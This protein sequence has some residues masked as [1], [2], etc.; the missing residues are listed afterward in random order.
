[1]AFASLRTPQSARHLTMGPRLPLMAWPRAARGQPARRSGGC[2][3]GQPR[4]LAHILGSA[5]AAS[6]FSTP[7]LSGMPTAIRTYASPFS[8][9][10]E[11][12]PS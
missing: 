10:M 5:S 8:T 2:D 11:A 3:R 7:R 6:V 9:L 1:M 12:Y 4:R